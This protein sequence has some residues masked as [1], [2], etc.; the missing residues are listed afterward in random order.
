MQDIFDKIIA[1][2]IPAQFVYEDDLC[3]VVMDKFPIVQG[4]V[5]VIPKEHTEYL[6]TTPDHTYEHLLQ[7]TKRV[8][9]ALDATYTPLRTCMVVEGFEVPHT[10]IKLYPIMDESDFKRHAGEAAEDIVLLRESEKIKAN[11]A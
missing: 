5:L 11:L 2:E 9:H 4:Q 8:V 1:R 7:V 10:H 3:I 6:F